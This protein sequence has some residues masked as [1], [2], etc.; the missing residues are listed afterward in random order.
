MKEI[1][2]QLF[3]S[4]TEPFR[5][6]QTGSTPVNSLKES[7]EPHFEIQRHEVIM[8]AN[9]NEDDNIYPPK[10]TT[11]QLEE[12]L[13]RDDTTNELHMPLS[14]TI[15]LKQKKEML[16]VSLDFGNGLT[17]DALVDSGAYVSAIAQTELYRTKQQSPANIFKIDDPTSFQTQVANGQLGKPIATATLKFYIG[18]N[19]F[20]EHFFVMKNSVHYKLALHET[21]QCAYQHHTWSHTLPTPENASQ[22]RCN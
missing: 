10:I 18:V 11:L 17:I 13:V 7:K 9:D 14:S 1:S 4:S 2:P 12:Q 5:G 21:Q 16:Y 8:T 3:G 22:K 15:V 19:T 20:E 6:N